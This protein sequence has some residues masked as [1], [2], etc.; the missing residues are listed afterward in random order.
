MEL[1]KREEFVSY[2]DRIVEILLSCP[3]AKAEARYICASALNEIMTD[4]GLCC[5]IR[6]Y[7]SVEHGD[8][9]KT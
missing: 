1:M 2:R 8:N 4:S 6:L 3:E 9:D 5:Q 7:R